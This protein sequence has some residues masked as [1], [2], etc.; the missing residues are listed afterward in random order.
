MLNLYWGSSKT[1]EFGEE[2]AKFR[3]SLVMQ[4]IGEVV[5]IYGSEVVAEK[6][7]LDYISLFLWHGLC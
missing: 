3:L 2:N 4:V 7:R 5:R 1:K 6:H